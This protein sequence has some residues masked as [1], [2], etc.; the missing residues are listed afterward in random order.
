MS[1]DNAKIPLAA[2]ALPAPVG[3]RTWGDFFM[4]SHRDPLNNETSA[5]V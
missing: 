5:W 2:A 3:A 4:Q 1:E